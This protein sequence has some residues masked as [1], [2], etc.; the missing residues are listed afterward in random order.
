MKAIVLDLKDG[1]SL[2]EMRDMP[3]PKIAPDE[4]LVKVKAASI[5]GTDISI[6]NYVPVMR[7]RIK[8]LPHI[9]GHEFAGHIVNIGSDVIEWKI[10][11]Y[12]SAETHIYCGACP[13]CLHDTNLKHVCLALKILGVDRDGCFAEYIAVPEKVLWRNKIDL[14]YYLASIQEPLGNAVYCVTDGGGVK[15]KTV[16]IIGDGPAALFATAI[17]K[18]NGAAEITVLGHHQKRLGIALKCGA[19]IAFDMSDTRDAEYI[20]D[21]LRVTYPEGFDVV[22][23]CSGANDGVKQAIEFVRPGGRIAVFGLTKEKNQEIN[24]NAIA[25]KIVNLRGI[26]GRIMWDTW[27]EVSWILKQHRGMIEP[28]ITH[29]LPFAEWQRGFDLMMKSKDCGKIVLLMEE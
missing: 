24:Y 12:V 5:C 15:G 28:I 4:V 20:Q 7:E 14:P 16:L 26:S 22:L 2:I 3:V 1:K 13:I 21:G 17:A 9:L 19:N 27:H 29:K 10:G 23:E 8:K 18:I 25:L 11:D 6:A